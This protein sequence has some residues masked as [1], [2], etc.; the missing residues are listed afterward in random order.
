[1]GQRGDSIGLTCGG[2]A[3][4]SWGAG[5]W[6]AGACAVMLLLASR[7]GLAETDVRLKIT[8]EGYA[9][10]SIGFAEPRGRL[11][12]DLL[13]QYDRFIAITR[14]DLDLSG[15]FEI[16]ESVKETRPNAAVAAS[17]EHQ[18]AD[19]SFEV[20]LTDVGSATAIFKHKYTSSGE[21]VGPAAH[22]AAEEIIFALTGRHSLAKTRVAFVAGERGG[23]HL[24]TAYLDGSAPQRLTDRPGIVMSPSWSADGARLAYV[25]YTEGRSAIYVMDAATWSATRFASYE[26]LNGMPAWSPD[27]KHIAVTLAKDG[28]PEI[29]ILALDGSSE[30]RVTFYSGIDCSPSWA[31]NGLELAFT[32]DR[33]GGP[34]VFVTDIEGLNVRQ[35]TTE[36]PYN[37]SPAWSPDGGLIAYV[38]RVDGKFQICTIDPFGVKSRALTSDRNN[39]DPSWSADGMHIVFSSTGD[40][41][42]G[43]YIV[44]RDGGHMRKVLGGMV[45]PRNPA[46]APPPGYGQQSP[47]G[48]QE[49]GGKK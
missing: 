10:I 8:T 25:S 12:A 20:T 6:V 15:Y 33:A 44:T 24:Y 11:E 40:G 5:A 32:S 23:S 41:D 21:D 14:Q 26:G 43:I 18:H 2:R 27:G 9:K 16:V 35:I 31:P 36:G 45:R 34:Q 49:E 47:A 4:S 38:S 46:W 48:E 7:A 1:M 3:R 22:A 37:T 42:S 29:Y 39:E 30:K 13:H 17:V 19:L 28:N